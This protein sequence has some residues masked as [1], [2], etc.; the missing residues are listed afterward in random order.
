M[1]QEDSTSSNAHVEENE[2]LVDLNTRRSL[3][4]S[5]LNATKE[6]VFVQIMTDPS[7]DLFLCLN[8]RTH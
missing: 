7:C 6:S 5:T 4:F 8:S 2:T 1:L 3:E